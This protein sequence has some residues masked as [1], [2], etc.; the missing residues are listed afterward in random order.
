MYF[1]S[2]QPY[3]WRTAVRSPDYKEM[4]YGELGFNPMYCI[5]AERLD[6]A[7]ISAILIVPVT[8]EVAVFFKTNDWWCVHKVSH[9]RALGGGPLP[10]VFSRGDL[11]ALYMQGGHRGRFED[12]LMGAMPYNFEFMV[13]RDSVVPFAEVDIKTV[14][15]KSLLSEGFTEEHLRG[16]I[17]Q[18]LESWEETYANKHDPFMTSDRVARN[19]EASC[20]WQW[21]CVENDMFIKDYK[22]S[23]GVRPGDRNVSMARVDSA[24]R[25]SLNILLNDDPSDENLAKFVQYLESCAYVE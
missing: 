3:D 13:N 10:I 23:I 8:P 6:I 9:Y 25:D 5:P 18:S 22:R 15:S 12:F 19:C 2:F 20:W 1:V 4:Y 17:A 21:Y 14:A 24:E 7:A 11:S 16:V